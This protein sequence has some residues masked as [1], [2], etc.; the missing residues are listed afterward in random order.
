MYG[1]VQTSGLL[2]NF[3]AGNSLMSEVGLTQ[4]YKVTKVEV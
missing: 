2:E 1:T 3:G 4:N